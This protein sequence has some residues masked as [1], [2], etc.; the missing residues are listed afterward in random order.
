MKVHDVII[1]KDIPSGMGARLLTYIV[2][3]VCKKPP[4]LGVCVQVRAL[5]SC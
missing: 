5:R 4:L 1:L 3:D 2:E